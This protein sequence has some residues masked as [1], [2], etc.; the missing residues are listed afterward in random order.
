MEAWKR[1][2]S[3]LSIKIAT[4]HLCSKSLKN[5]Y[6][7]NHFLIQLPNLHLQ[8]YWKNILHIYFLEV[9]SRDSEDLSFRIAFCSTPNFAEHH[10]TTASKVTYKTTIHNSAKCFSSHEK[11]KKC[12]ST[13][14]TTQRLLNLA[15]KI[16]LNK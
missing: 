6:K 11:M 1:P 10:S 9:L 13:H 5:N 3:P 4:L 12:F 16:L 15:T 8:L 2:P 7:I 14:K